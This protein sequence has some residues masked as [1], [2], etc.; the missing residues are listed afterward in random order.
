MCSNNIKKTV[1]TDIRTVSNTTTNNAEQVK[2]NTTYVSDVDTEDDANIYMSK[3]VG[4]K[5]YQRHTLL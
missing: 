4:H 5:Q 2:T 1:C 3:C